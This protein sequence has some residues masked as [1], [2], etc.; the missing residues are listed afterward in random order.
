VT[1]WTIESGGTGAPRRRRAHGFAGT[2]LMSTEE[3]L[4]VLQELPPAAAPHAGREQ[5]VTHP[6]APAPAPSPPA[7]ATDSARP[8]PAGPPRSSPQPHAPTGLSNP[9]PRPSL[10]ARLHCAR[11]GH[12]P[13]PHRPGRNDEIVYRCL[14]CGRATPPPPQYRGTSAMRS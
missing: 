9:A 13:R 6:Q 10:G 5:A 2:L 8:R 4:A 3:L 14:C 11:H 1:N 7:P 12:D